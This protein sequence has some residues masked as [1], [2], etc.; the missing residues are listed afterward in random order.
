[1]IVGNF[2]VNCYPMRTI[3]FYKIFLHTVTLVLKT[4]VVVLI[5]ICDDDYSV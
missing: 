4:R 3:D 2:G 5:K 1:M